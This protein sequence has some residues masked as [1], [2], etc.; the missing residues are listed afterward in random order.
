MPQESTQI[1]LALY[2]QKKKKASSV[3]VDIFLKCFIILLILCKRRTVSNVFLMLH[4]TKALFV[5]TWR[6][7]KCP[8]SVLP[9]MFQ[10]QFCLHASQR[11]NLW[12]DNR[13]HQTLFPIQFW[14]IQSAAEDYQ[15]VSTAHF[16]C[17]QG[18]F[19]IQS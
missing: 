13:E 10:Q 18:I 2:C 11:I 14:F 17:I 15:L 9:N 16:C 1:N 4:G 7:Q 3:P 5:L 19:H 6:P 12:S 8:V